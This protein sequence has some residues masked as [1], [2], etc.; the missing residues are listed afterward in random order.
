[1]ALKVSIYDVDSS[2]GGAG[3]LISDADGL[4]SRLLFPIRDANILFANLIGSQQ[5]LLLGEM[6][7]GIERYFT[8]IVD[9]DSGAIIRRSL[10]VWLASGKYLITRDKKHLLG[11][12]MHHIWAWSVPDLTS[13]T[14]FNLVEEVD[15][16]FRIG[17]SAEYFKIAES[18]RVF[19]SENLEA[20]FESKIQAEKLVFLGNR[21]EPWG[22]TR[23]GWIQ[24]TN[25]RAIYGE[26]GDD[27]FKKKLGEERYICR[28]DPKTLECLKFE[29]D[30]KTKTD[31]IEPW[32][33]PRVSYRKADPAYSA[34]A[35]AAATVTV[36]IASL[37]A[38]ACAEA[39]DKLT[40]IIA[41]GVDSIRLYYTLRFQFHLRDE[42]KGTDTY[43]KEHEFAH[44]LWGVHLVYFCNGDRDFLEE[45]AA[46]IAPSL[47]RLIVTYL[48]HHP[49]NEQIYHD[50]DNGI[51]VFDPFVGALLIMDPSRLDTARRYVASLD[52]E[53]C[54]LEGL[55]HFA[56]WATS[57]ASKPDHIRAAIYC[58]VIEGDE[59]WTRPTFLDRAAKVVTGQQFFDLALDELKNTD[60]SKITSSIDL[61]KNN[62][63]HKFDFDLS[64]ASE[65]WGVDLETRLEMQFLQKTS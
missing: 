17:S 20:E 12:S 51:A 24:F 65:T 36:Q 49:K 15:G 21:L 40:E 5:I 14:Y 61:L 54:S 55:N 47:D 39:L 37:E 38:S 1:M 30:S 35:A 4:N 41:R 58:R 26:L 9:A 18:K 23:D 52:R 27:G 19:H 32:M 25:V 44:K 50:S 60:P 28:F 2:I 46:I 7:S 31:L 34:Q 45:R 10:P 43:F 6:S 8:A 56:G 62:L 63:R 11:L 22:E 53:H 13:Y 3:L 64:R 59:A 16:K 57:W 33:T 42:I 29:V 48:D